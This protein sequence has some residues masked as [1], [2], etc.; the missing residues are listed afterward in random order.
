MASGGDINGLWLFFHNSGVKQ[1]ASHWKVHRQSCVAYHERILEAAAVDDGLLLDA[2]TELLAKQAR[3]EAACKSAGSLRGEKSVFITHILGHEHSGNNACSH[4]GKDAI[5]MAR[6]LRAA[7][8]A[9]KSTGSKHSHTESTSITTE[10]SS[11]APPSKK[12]KQPSIRT[13]MHTGTEMPFS[14]IQIKAIQDQALCAVISANLPF[15]V[16]KNPEVLNANLTQWTTHCITFLWLL[17]VKQALQNAVM[18][19]RPAIIK[20]QVGVATSA[21]HRHLTADA[22][23]HCDVIENYSFWDGL[24]QVV[25]DIEP[26]CYGTNINQKD[27]T[28]LD[29]ILLTLAGM[30]L[31][32]S[33]HPEPKV[34]AA[35]KKCLEKRWKDCDQ[36]IFILALVLNPFEGL[37][38]FGDSAGLNYIKLNGIVLRL[39]RRL[40][41]RPDNLDGPELRGQ[42]ECA[43][44][45]AFFHFLALTGP[46][47]S[48]RDEAADFPSTDPIT[49]WFAFQS[50]LKVAELGEF[51]LILLKVVASQ[52]GVERIFSDLKVKQTHCR[53][54]LR[55]AKLGK[56]TKV[57]ADIKAKHQALGLAKTR[58]K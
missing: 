25:R 19:L 54:H 50:I 22:K 11:S 8:K 55:L 29:Q 30:Y 1:N 42:K 20:A 21:E 14:A 33:E 41:S 5:D 10:S 34:S 2:G 47:A 57:G 38:R 36:Q 39:Y 15:H 24:E 12:L 31:H 6:A 3:F 23:E 26:I 27:S 44:S 48:W 32:F 40:H 56:M 4:A 51:A 28:R 58:G 49:A 9:E 45:T 17:L 18:E 7:S 13:H 53:A 46:F 37:S 43:V 16:Y 52:G 35:M